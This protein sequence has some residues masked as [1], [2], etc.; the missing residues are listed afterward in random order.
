METN[1]VLE[2]HEIIKS[3][4]FEHADSMIHL[5]VGG[6]ASHGAKLAGSGD[7]DLYGVYIPPPRM[8]LGITESK[9]DGEGT[10]RVSIKPDHFVWSSAGDRKRNGPED[11]DFTAY[12][13]R[14]WAGMAAKGNATALHFLFTPNLAF[15]PSTWEKHIRPHASLFV[16]SIAGFHFKKFAEDELKRL[17][18]ILGAGKHGQRPELEERYGYDTKAAMQIA[19]ILGEGIELMQ[20]GKIT[21]PRPEK[22]FLIGIRKGQAGSL[23]QFNRLAE[24]LFIKLD[25]ARLKSSLPLDVDRRKISELVA[26]TYMDFYTGGFWPHA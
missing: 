2:L 4:E 17:N 5:F 7:L 24:D 3:T 12:S 21:L 15:K 13:L 26:D 20:S 11:V 22:D 10:Q 16:S 25:Q 18:G 8:A 1:R 9:P 6:S 23:T 19:R 14:K